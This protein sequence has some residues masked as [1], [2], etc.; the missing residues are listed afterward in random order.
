MSW[1]KQK[2]KTNKK[3]KKQSKTWKNIHVKKSFR[4]LKERV[5]GTDGLS[6]ST[7]HMD[8]G[9]TSKQVSGLG[10]LNGREQGRS[11]L[12]FLFLQSLE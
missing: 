12:V 3:T 11:A 2:Q 8:I 6:T 10:R 4:L 1:S 5:R 7:L 9:V